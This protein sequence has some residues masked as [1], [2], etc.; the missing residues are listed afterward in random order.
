MLG[1]LPSIISVLNSHSFHD[2]IT[3]VLAVAKLLNFRV[4]APPRTGLCYFLTC[5]PE[6]ARHIFTR[7]FVNYPTGDDFATM[8]PLLESTIF[9]ADDEPWRR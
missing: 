5:D 4:H 2:S 7:S 3:S 1:I 9:T 8:L 6:N